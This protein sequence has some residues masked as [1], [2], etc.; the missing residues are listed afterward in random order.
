MGGRNIDITGQKFNML[1]AIKYLGN[2][3]WLFKCDCGI[4]KT[5]DS[6]TVKSKTSA[7]KS[8]GCLLKRFNFNNKTKH[9]LSETVEYDAWTALRNRCYN[10]K[11][12]AY[13]HYGKRGI[14][15]C[16]RWLESFD[17]F[18]TDMGNKP[19]KDHSIDRINVNGNYEP[20]NC[21]WATS[22][23]QQD[24]RTNTRKLTYN[25]ETKTI[26]EWAKCLNIDYALLVS[27]YNLGWDTKDIIETP[28]DKRF[29]VKLN[30]EKVSEI[31]EFPT[32]TP[33]QEIADLYGVSYAT[34][35]DIRNNRRW[36][37]QQNA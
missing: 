5:I 34:I 12:R 25:N 7:T 13:K 1:T 28:S 29:I 15:V 32:N 37:I 31:R 16:E 35:Y 9:N 36:K 33:Y 11:N 23:E 24:N 22:Q 18:I 27:R 3:K 2:S 6:R 26:T 20:S 14:I 21:R 8:C 19:S 17:N 10:P 30:W 4:E